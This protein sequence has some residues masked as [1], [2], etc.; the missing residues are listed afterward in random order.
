M[1]GE[2]GRFFAL[3]TFRF[4]W[5][6]FLGLEFQDLFADLM[7]NAWPGD[8]QKV[9]PYGPRGDLKC[10][11]YWRSRRCVFQCYGPISMRERDIIAK[12]REDLTGAV[13][14]WEGRMQRWSFVHNGMQGLT[15]KVVQVIDELR[16]T[17][18]KVEIEEWA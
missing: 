17:Y 18:P 9:R 3:Q 10:D 5:F 2:T 15:A 7:Q 14:N 16:D 1:M 13:A 12:I 6:T 11:G 4:R 8:F